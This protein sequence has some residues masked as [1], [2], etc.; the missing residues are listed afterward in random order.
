VWKI[1]L[2]GKGQKASAK[3]EF[4]PD[5]LR[6]GQDGQILVTGQFLNPTK[7]GGPND[8][9]VARLD[10]EVMHVTTLLTAPG[11]PEFDNATTAV[12]A[13]NMLWLG[14]FKGDR[15]AYMPAP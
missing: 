11:M 14:T 4:N 12:R 9:G 8:W 5:N 13:A 7:P 3:I 10:P 2:N 6:W 1:P 15:I